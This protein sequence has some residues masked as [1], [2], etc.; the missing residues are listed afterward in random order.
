MFYTI[1]FEKFKIM[2]ENK[3][4]FLFSFFSRLA[5]FLLTALTVSSKAFLLL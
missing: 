4:S 3:L 1:G 5:K 2:W